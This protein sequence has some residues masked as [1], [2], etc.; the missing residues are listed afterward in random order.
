[1]IF[2]RVRWIPFWIAMLV[3]CLVNVLGDWVIGIRI[4]LFWGLDTFNFLWFLQLFIWPVV[5]G[6][7][8]SYVYGLGGKWIA[9]FPPLI[10]RFAAYFQTVEFL[11]VPQGAALMPL[12]WWGFFVIL[13]MET[14]MIGGV[15]GEIMNKRVYGWKKAP[16]V[17]DNA[18]DVDAEIKE[19]PELSDGNR[20]VD[21]DKNAGSGV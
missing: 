12:G 10:V 5:V 13:A 8:V 3:G 2:F 21:S 17:S 7:A 14:A 11:G 20:Q 16:H 9:I 18:T 6:I 1:M 15:F 4:E 19:D